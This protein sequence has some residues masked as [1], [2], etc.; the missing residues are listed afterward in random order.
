MIQSFNAYKQNGL[1]LYI[2][3][4]KYVGSKILNRP[5]LCRLILIFFK[6]KINSNHLITAS[7]HL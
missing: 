4:Q 1:N 7:N 3:T 6:D 5:R 2:V